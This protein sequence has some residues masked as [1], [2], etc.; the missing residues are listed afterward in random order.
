MN[1][2]GEG[3]SIVDSSQLMV[4]EGGRELRGELSEVGVD[5]M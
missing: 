3:E 5:V 1:S 2:M 4:A